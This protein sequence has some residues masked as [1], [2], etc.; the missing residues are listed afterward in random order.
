VKGITPSSYVGFFE[1]PFL[2]Y[3]YEKEM[4]TVG[5]SLLEFFWGDVVTHYFL[6]ILKWAVV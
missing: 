4:I 3:I 1:F 5:E 6:T 2:A